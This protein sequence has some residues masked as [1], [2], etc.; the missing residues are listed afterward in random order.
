MR[1]KREILIDKMSKVSSVAN[2]KDA[3]GIIRFDLL[4]ENDETNIGFNLRIFAS[5][6]I[7][8]VMTTMKVEGKED[9]VGTYYIDS[10]K[11]TNYLKNLGAFEVDEIDIM[12]S[13]EKISIL[14]GKTMFDF[15]I[16]VVEDYPV[17]PAMDLDSI[18]GE[19]YVV[20]CD[21]MT[22]HRKMMNTAKTIYP[23]YDK[24]IL[25]YT[26]II[27]TQDGL[28]LVSSDGFRITRMLM[29]AEVINLKT[30]QPIPGE[31]VTNINSMVL[32]RL[33]TPISGV[34][35]SIFITDDLIYVVDSESA[36]SL[37]TIKAEFP[38]VRDIIPKADF[39]SNQVPFK[40]IWT[41]EGKEIN[42]SLSLLKAVVINEKNKRVKFN[43]NSEGS[44]IE[45][46]QSKDKGKITIGGEVI[47][48]GID[49]N[50]DINK[51]D[52]LN[53]GI[54]KLRICFTEANKPVIIYDYSETKEFTN[55]FLIMPIL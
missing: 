26:N 14:T 40:T 16:E 15:P 42:N 29:D 53:N 51:L 4:E 5:D 48:E 41:I 20:T 22:L 1:V 23:S 44:F 24:P 45:S 38:K 28:D 33:L 19:K 10:R 35:V 9:R 36:I 50:F 55:S 52:V 3:K 17:M 27:C 25:Q 18:E 30:K 11:V 49:V 21:S 43:I 31:I 32:A 47:G 7:N 39:K 8:A 37:K 13:D 12:L 6:G 2:Y 46:D 54:E 34:E